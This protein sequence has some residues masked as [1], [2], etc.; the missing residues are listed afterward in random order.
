MEHSRI[1]ARQIEAARKAIRRV[2]KRSGFLWIKIF[3][4]LP[5]SSKPSEIRMGKGKGSVSY[6]AT[7][8]KKYSIPFELTGVS[9]Q[10][11]YKALE[12]ASVKLPFKTQI[13]IQKR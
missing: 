1:S 13:I 6:W 12:S 3:P 4:H 7:F 2:T 5:V 11:A 9:N 8:V 10:I